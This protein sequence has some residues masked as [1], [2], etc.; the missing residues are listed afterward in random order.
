MTATAYPLTWPEGW[1]RTAPERRR[2]A[3]F[4][5]GER[6]H[7]STPGGGS[8]MRQKP[9]TV[10][11][12]TERVLAELGRMHVRR[13]DVV[14][15]TNVELRLDGLPRSGQRAPADPG[16]AVYWTAKGKERRCIAVDQYT[17][18]EDNLAAIAATLD[19]M[20]AIERHGGAEILHRAFTGFTALPA[21]GQTVVRGW[22]EI[23]EVGPGERNVEVVKDR[24]RRLAAVRHPDKGGSHG[25]MA[26][27][28]WAWAQAQ[29]SL[30]ASA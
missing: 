7:S 22:R 12:S 4:T 10:S 20:R 27:L 5:Q 6:V 3:K 11:V 29:E 9:V 26:E 23:L 18:V 24:Y 19:A 21:P 1:K 16:V 28:N 14:I 8:W 25:A 2:V 13:E 17:T 15:S 30:R